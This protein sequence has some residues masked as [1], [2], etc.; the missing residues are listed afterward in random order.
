MIKIRILPL[1][2]IAATLVLSSVV[3]VTSERDGT[4]GFW[5]EKGGREW[6]RDRP[7]EWRRERGRDGDRGEQAMSFETF[8]VDG[9][10]DG[11]VNIEDITMAAKAKFADADTSGEGEVSI[12][13][14][15]ANYVT[16]VRDSLVD[17]FQHIDSDASGQITEQELNKV[18]IDLIGNIDRNAGGEVN[19]KDRFH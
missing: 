18:L 19:F 6:S 17:A 7:R 14:F 2:V 3:F 5:G 15:E 13:E 11:K 4:A 9:D 12:K 16:L 1:G 10:S 8:L